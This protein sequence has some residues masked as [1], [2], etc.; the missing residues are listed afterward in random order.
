MFDEFYE[1]DSS[2]EEEYNKLIT[3]HFDNLVNWYLELAEENYR[4]V[5]Y[6]VTNLQDLINKGSEIKSIVQLH[7]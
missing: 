3:K 2:D 4:Y 6:D 7:Y 1:S 5:R